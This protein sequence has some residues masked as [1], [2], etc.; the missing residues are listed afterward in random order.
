MPKTLKTYAHWLRK[1]QV[2]TRSK[3]LESSC[4]NDITDFMT[5]LAVKRNVPASTQ[6]QAFNSVLF[7]FRRV[8]GREPCV[9]KNSVRAKRRPYVPVVLSRNEIEAVLVH[10]SHS[11]DLAFRMLYGCGLR[12]F[13]CLKLRI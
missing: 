2:F 10:L 3:P 5:C 7:F 4:D 13:E 9:L 11:C 12:L 8:P 1:F 6:N